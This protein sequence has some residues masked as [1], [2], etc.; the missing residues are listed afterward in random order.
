ML[1]GSILN[2]EHHGTENKKKIENKTL[3]SNTPQMFFLS[4]EKS[5]VSECGISSICGT[6]PQ[7]VHKRLEERVA[8]G[9]R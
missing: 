5:G 9:P 1:G 6:N 7:L 4:L 3:L 2:I 8:K